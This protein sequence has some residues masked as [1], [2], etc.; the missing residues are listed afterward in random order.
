MTSRSSSLPLPIALFAVALLSA[1]TARAGND[2]GVL[3]GNEAAMTG[4]AVAAVT[5]DGSAVWYNPAGIAAAR[6]SSVDVNGSIF[7][8]RGAE[9]WG[10][11]QATSGERNN[12]GYLSLINIPS[13]VTLVRRVDDRVNLAIGL[14]ATQLVRNTTRANVDAMSAT[15]AASW[16]L[17]SVDNRTRYHAGGALGYRVDDR[18][19]I[20]FNVFFVYN[21]ASSSFQSAAAPPTPTAP[22]RSS[23]SEAWSIS[24][25]SASRSA[26]ACSGSPS[27]AC[28][29]A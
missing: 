16:A 27:T 20:G 4:G 9:E 15:S 7:M 28:S 12:G 18:L 3:L 26:S 19:R 22:R 10:L 14:F 13:A 29:W 23:R 17:T 2:D 8:L 1:S 21:E 6:R 11:L 24:R 25:R 5:S